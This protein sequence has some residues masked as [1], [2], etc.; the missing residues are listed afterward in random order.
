[1]AYF[2]GEAIEP[3]RRTMRSANTNESGLRQGRAMSTPDLVS[4]HRNDPLVTIAIPTFNRAPL[5]RDC[6]A[7]AL[8]QTYSNFEVLVSDNAST[9]ETRETL[10]EF[11]DPRF[12]VIRQERNIGLLPNW[13]SC[14]AGAKGEYIV[15]LSDDDRIA[16]WLLERCIGVIG[17]QPQVPI[18]FT[19][20]NLRVASMEKTWPARSSRS[21]ETGICDGTE[22][23]MEYLTNQISVS[24][25]SI[26][27]RTELLRARGGLPLDLPHAADVAA[28]APLL[29]LGKAGF[30]NE[31]CATYY[32][33]DISETARLGIEQLLCDGWKVAALISHVANQQISDLSQRRII[34]RQIQRGFARR[35]LMA[36]S[37]YRHIG[38]SLQE[39]LSCV[40]RFR[41]ELSH[42]DMTAALRFGATICCP[43]PIAERIRRL[44]QTVPDLSAS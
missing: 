38:G 20:S 2:T 29:F 44:K 7:S 16:P 21:L 4:T 23:L 27:L 37:Y 31:A 42:V 34:Q 19:L 30:V 3:S 12:R 14:L 9:D 10:S 17:Q 39:I 41:D 13:N 32:D 18:V 43:R 40:W 28:W 8:A 26:M 11:T 15:F 6:V 25:C 24:M 36:L 35:G 33:H 1:M 22:I 5:L